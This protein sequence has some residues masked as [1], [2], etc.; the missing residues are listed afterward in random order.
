LDGFAT[1]LRATDL[2]LET[3]LLE[4][5]SM[6]AKLGNCHFPRSSLTHGELQCV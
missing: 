2:Q 6:L 4:N 3:M 5:A 1:A